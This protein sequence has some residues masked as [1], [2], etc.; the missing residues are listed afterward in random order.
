MTRKRDDLLARASV[1]SDHQAKQ[2]TRWGPKQGVEPI[3]G[4]WNQ[5]DQP[6]QTLQECLDAWL[7]ENE[8]TPEAIEEANQALEE[9]ASDG[10]ESVLITDPTYP[11]Q[12]RTIPNPPVVLHIAGDASTLNTGI[13]VIGSRQADEDALEVTREFSEWLA[14]AGVP[15]ITGLALGVDRTAARAALDAGGT[16]IGAVPGGASEIVPKACKEEYVRTRRSGCLITEVTDRSGVEKT[17]FLRRNRI[18]SGLS[19]VVV[20]TATRK[21]GGSINQLGWAKRQGIPSIVLEEG[22]PSDFTTEFSITELPYHF[23][24]ANRLR[25]QATGLWAQPSLSPQT[26]LPV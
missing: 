3:I 26:S 19:R 15:V 24:Q 4:T 8:V 9:Q 2:W 20:V 14:Q 13:A 11:P 21:T 1:A 18:T 10:V 17:S 25:D 23:T 7:E 12:L 5:T 22:A 6:E 16:V